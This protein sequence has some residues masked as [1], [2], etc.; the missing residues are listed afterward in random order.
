MRLRRC[1]GKR[2]FA[3]VTGSRAEYGLLRWIMKAIMEDPGLVLQLLVTGSHLSPRFGMTVREIEQDGIP[4]TERI[5]ILNERDTPEAITEAMSAALVGFGRAY[6][7]QKPDCLVVLGDRFEVF[8]AVSAAVPF[9]IPVAHLMGGELTEGAMDESFRHAMTKMS[10]LHFVSTETYRQRVIQMGEDPERV[11]SVGALGLDG[12]HRL[13]LLDRQALAMELQ[14]PEKKSWGVMTYHPVTL[15]AEHSDAEL[16]AILEALKDFPDVFWILGLP[17]ADQGNRRIGE[18]LQVFVQVNPEVGCV[19][20]S[21]GQTRYLSLLKY[22]VVMVGNSSSGIVEAPSFAL[23]V[24]NVGLRQRGR[25]RARNVID[26]SS[27]DPMV[28]AG[29]IRQALHPSFRETLVGLVNPF[30]DG[31]ASTKILKILA[32]H[33]LGRE[34]QQ[35]RFYDMVEVHHQ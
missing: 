10:H 7:R 16:S 15:D 33:P 17:N 23:A 28:I 34:L 24:V 26:V 20:D 30:G 21:L 3:I 31:A 22:A 29:A 32:S 35:K 5:A 2:R 12:I 4:I 13:T 14:V 18:Q 19:K 6:A 1:M 27:R 25:I 8:A 9:C 11:F